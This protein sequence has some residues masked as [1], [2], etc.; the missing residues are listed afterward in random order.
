MILSNLFD[1]YKTYPS[2]SFFNWELADSSNRKEK[3][4]SS[5]FTQS[6]IPNLTIYCILNLPAIRLSGNIN[7]NLSEPSTTEA[8][9]WF[10]APY[11]GLAEFPLN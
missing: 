1:Q 10:S 5:F 7:Q 11:E 8:K 4:I 9:L 2:Y 3:G 6:A